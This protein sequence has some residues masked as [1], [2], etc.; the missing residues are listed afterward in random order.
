VV[1][2]NVVTYSLKYSR[3]KLEKYIIVKCIVVR[4][5][6][7]ILCHVVSCLVYVVNLLTALKLE[8][9]HGIV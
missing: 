9:L 3:W 7:K 1:V 8:D 5:A 2:G 4:G 6:S